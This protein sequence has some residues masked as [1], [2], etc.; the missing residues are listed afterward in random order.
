[1][2][3]S[4][5][6]IIDAQVGAFNFPPEMYRGKETLS[7]INR[8]TALARSHSIPVIFIQH[9]GPEGSPMAHSSA[10]WQ[11]HPDLV[12]ES[13]DIAIQK[14]A[15]DSFHETRLHSTL[16]EL[17]VKQI[18]LGGYA[19]ELCVDTTAR[20]AAVLGYK[21]TLVAD[22]HTTKNRPNLSAEQIIAHHHWVLPNIA[23]PGNQISVNDIDEL[24]REFGAAGA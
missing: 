21:T 18:F 23:C 8:L 6:L 24:V 14:T 11:L 1:M 2:S 17:N 3:R 16:Q 10:P 4:A 22:A 19:T 13:E 15:G 5:V 7:S 20:R 9:T 12:V